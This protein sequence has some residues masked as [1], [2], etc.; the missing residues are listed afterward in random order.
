MNKR[1]W[2]WV[3]G[4]T[5]VVAAIVGGFVYTSLNQT[6]E[7]ET[8]E[9]TPTEVIKTVS[10]NG[11]LAETQLLAYG[12]SEEPVLVSANGSN[13]IPV[14]FGLSLEIEEILVSA[15][16]SVDSGD[17]LFS[18]LDQMG[19]STEVLAIAAGIVRSVDTA[20]GLRTSSS[21][22]TV[23]S[24]EPIV[25]VFVSEYDA[26]LVSLDQ[27]TSIE[28]DAINAVFEGEV[29]RIGQVAQSVSG[30]KQYE[31][32]VAVNNVPTGARF[33]MSATAEIEVEK[34]VDVLAI[35][36]GALIGD[37]P[38]VEILTIDAEGNQSVSL[39]EVELGLT[40]DS[41]VEV[42]GGLSVGDQVVTGVSGTIP[43]P[44]NFGPPPGARNNG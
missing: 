19:D 10:A 41:L 6:V 5:A 3:L 26:D 32:L 7:Y 44:V 12:P 40:G 42:V 14:Q 36:M 9:V 11:Q 29:I 17:V 8:F 35:P 21:V 37:I 22:M 2:P 38:E 30:I 43:A 24:A 25:A 23:G 31:V 33:G 18:Y 4:T 20:E 27:K 15:G 13:A 28:L 1:R 34:K 39:V 16:D